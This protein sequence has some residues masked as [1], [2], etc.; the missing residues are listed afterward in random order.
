ML[1][2]IAVVAVVVLAV[3]AFAATRPKEFRVE[4]AATI[5]APPER[6]YGLINDLRGWNAW[7][8]WEKLDPAMTR[9]FSGAASGPGAVYEWAGNGKVGAGRMEITEA[10]A[11]SALTIKLDFLRPFEGHNVARFT[12]AP[13]G[14]ATKITWAMQGPQ[15]FICKLMGLVMSMD[16]MIGRQFENGLANLKA[17][18]EA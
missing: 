15:S 4:R 5:Q 14:A 2:T 6:I 1:T 13:V 8:P 7:S 9:N 10:S 3:L 17:I 18:A 11:P 12:L 16:R